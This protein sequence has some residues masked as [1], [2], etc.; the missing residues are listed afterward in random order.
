M[1][2]TVQAASITESSRLIG[3]VCLLMLLL[4]GTAVASSDDAAPVVEFTV[5]GFRIDGDNP[6]D[7]ATTERILAPYVG[8][9][10]GL[11]RLFD[12][13][14]QLEKAILDAGNSFYRVTLPPQTM[15]AGRITLKI[16]TI[17]VASVEVVGNRYFSA[18]NIRASVPG[19]R[20]G[21]TPDTR[22]LAR[23]L[24]VA[25]NHAA[26]QVTLR[27]KQASQP[28]SVDVTLAVRD[29]KPWKLFASL[30]N[31]GS[32]DTGDY[33]LGVGFQH[34]NL[35]DL[36]HELTASYTTSPG[37]V[38]DVRQYGFDYRAPLYRY[39]GEVALFYSRST[40]DTGVVAQVFDVSGAGRFV[41]ASY[42]QTFDN[43]DNYRHKASL[44]LEDRSFGNDISFLG[45]PVGVDVRSRPV[46]LEYR[47]EYV[48]ERRRIGFSLGYT[49]NIP[50]GRHNDT[51]TYSASRA[52][53]D[54][55]WHA[56]RFSANASQALGGQWVLS[57]SLAGQYTWE[58]LIS[59]EQFGVGG[60]N[61]VRGFEE[62]AIAGDR[63]LRASLEVMTPPVAALR[64]ARFVGFVDAGHVKSLKTVAGQLRSDTVSSAGVGL[65]WQWN[66]QLN[67]QLD[68]AHA[69]R[70]ARTPDAGGTKLHLRVFYSY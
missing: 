33:R 41:G 14:A 64:D 25:N 59:G 8:R 37:H 35:F 51:A 23:Q 44:A 26:K 11:D 58:P 67:V 3:C 13:V 9:H 18:P 24:Q 47:G 6:L 63:G 56:L 12:A 34:A 32:D 15:E 38:G 16:V 20:V 49:R 50:R 43:I 2:A 65:R 57:G 17:E 36:D 61:S 19:L 7:E 29:Q 62:R 5:S 46:T 69:L 30:G 52:G 22:E 53:A 48:Q 40:V 39:S 70:K 55:N 60:V 31:T 4:S 10:E 66:R 45:T 42:T 21:A 27:M 1:P 68:Y 28:D 54:A